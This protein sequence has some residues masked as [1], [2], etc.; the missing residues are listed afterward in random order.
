MEALSKAGDAELAN[1]RRP[2]ILLS[3]GGFLPRHT[4]TVAVSRVVSASPCSRKPLQ[5][6]P[7]ASGGSVGLK[8][9]QKNQLPATA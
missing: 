3:A 9:T 5:L 6:A 7:L 8:T 4:A 1:L 2:Q